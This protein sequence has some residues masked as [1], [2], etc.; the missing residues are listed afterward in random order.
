MQKSQTC[1]DLLLANPRLQ[2]VDLITL[3]ESWRN[4]YQETSTLTVFSVFYPLQDQVLERTLVLINRRI[5]RSAITPVFWSKNLT[6]LEIRV[7]AKVFW[8]HN[9]YFTPTSQENYRVSAEALLDVLAQA[10]EKEGEHIL[11]TDSN[12]HHPSWSKSSQLY[13]ELATK[14]DKAIAEQNSSLTDP[15][16]LT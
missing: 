6:S 1:Q 2:E 5:Q 8:V 7:Q 16:T 13:S 12:L 15:V 11:L 9:L 4:P 3:Q 14:C 10:L